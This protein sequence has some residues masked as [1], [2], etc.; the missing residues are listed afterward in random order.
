MIDHR[1]SRRVKGCGLV[2]ALSIVAAACGG[3]TSDEELSAVGAAELMNE[4]MGGTQAVQDFLI[5]LDMSVQ[6]DDGSVS[7]YDEVL[8]RAA[9]GSGEAVELAGGFSLA[10]VDTLV[11]DVRTASGEQVPS[12]ALDFGL[13]TASVE[14]QAAGLDVLAEIVGVAEPDELP[15]GLGGS[16]AAR[17]GALVEIFTADIDERRTHVGP[18]DVGAKDL[19][20]VSGIA[21]GDD[22]SSVYIFGQ[23]LPGEPSAEE[24][25]TAHELFAYRWNRGL[26]S[27][28]GRDGVVDIVFDDDVVAVEGSTLVL[29]EPKAIAVRE[30]RSRGTA[31]ALHILAE[32][33]TH[34]FSAGPYGGSIFGERYIVTK[35]GENEYKVWPVTEDGLPVDGAEV[36]GDLATLSRY[37][38]PLLT[39]GSCERELARV[40][41]MNHPIHADLD[42]SLRDQGT[43]ADAPVPD[44][45]DVPAG[46]YCLQPNPPSAKAAGT[47]GD[48][49]ITTFDGWSYDNQAAGE[50]LVFDNGTATVQMRS[51]PWPGSDAVSVVTAVAARV[52]DHEI[53]MHQ[54][55]RIWVD[56]VEPAI[57]RGETIAVGDAALLF[58][59]A[60]WVIV[61]P[62]GTELRV[63]GGQ[64]NVLPDAQSEFHPLMM[65]LTTAS[66]DVI[67]MLGS[68][69][70]DGR[71][72]WVTR[73]GEQLDDDIRF[74]FENFY[75]TYIDT[76][77]VSDDE[78]LFHYEPGESTASFTVEG[79][80]RVHYDIADLDPAAAAHAEAACLE[81]GIERAD[82]LDGCILDVA[83][84]GDEGFVY[85]TYLAQTYT[86]P[87]P[88][89]SPDPV[90]EPPPPNGETFVTVG[91]L[92][93]AF[94]AE[95]PIIVANFPAQ[96]QCQAADGSFS[97]TS[98]FQE[99]EDR[100]YEIVVDYLD[101]E[102]SRDGTERFTLVVRR[103][104]DPIAWMQTTVDPMP[105]TID[106]IELAGSTLTVTGTALLNEP[107]DSAVFPGGASLG[108]AG[109]EPLRL[110]VHCDR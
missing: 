2:V 87:P 61:W 27:I 100:Q 67:G 93:V 9:E 62:D 33:S 46:G 107:F 52:D 1:P 36:T 19:T 60:A 53:A 25:L 80:P 101:A 74:D 82:M 22:L 78:S 48:V 30:A 99:S 4:A 63:S 96:W 41:A 14:T 51:A 23:T 58:T 84:T 17:S 6:A 28:P 59:G 16:P 98:R 5:Y 21:P 69:D 39:L 77:R 75:P 56:G 73:S 12:V 3:G 49:H 54:D 29:T 79:F 47:Y 64:R 105:G 57:G 42:E 103:N 18:G 66:E 81:G 31:R 26:V 70:D 108:S 35:S 65:L 85:D 40:R 76:W 44:R 45:L 94:G 104:A 91:P 110:V 7:Y 24:S 50:F 90:S 102:T 43:N 68:P 92:S 55:N 20:F 83:L 34:D 37:I 86:T 72:D 89:T 88:A 97:A 8:D 15:F 32:I 106:T 109:L 95:P 10:A 13:L 71:N 38:T 11:G